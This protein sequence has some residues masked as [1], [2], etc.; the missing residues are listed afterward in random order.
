MKRFFLLIIMVSLLAAACSDAGNS[1]QSPLVEFA[2]SLFQASIDSN[3]IAGASVIVFQRDEILLDK[4]YGFASIEL[5]LMMLHLKLDLLQS[6]LLQ[7]Q[8]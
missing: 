6:N 3:M 5:Y 1:K 4:S 7:L 2:D 8:F